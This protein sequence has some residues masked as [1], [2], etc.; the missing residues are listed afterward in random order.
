M[1]YI[2]SFQSKENPKWKTMFYICTCTCTFVH[3]SWLFK[4][5]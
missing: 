5:L 4:W 1:E 2:V 3:S